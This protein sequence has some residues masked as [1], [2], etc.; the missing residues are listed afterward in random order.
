MKEQHDFFLKHDRYTI[1]SKIWNKT[2]EHWSYILLIDSSL[3]NLHNLCRALDI[4]SVSHFCGSVKS[5]GSLHADSLSR[6]WNE[7]YLCRL[8]T[9]GTHPAAHF[10]RRISCTACFWSSSAF[11]QQRSY[12]KPYATPN[13]GAAD[14]RR[15]VQ[16]LA[17]SREIH[18]SKYTP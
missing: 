12:S 11:S 3:S 7:E 18:Q 1:K 5:L 6:Y 2:K 8:S 15:Q 4:Q 17:F 10:R 9:S 14:S 13:A 16:G